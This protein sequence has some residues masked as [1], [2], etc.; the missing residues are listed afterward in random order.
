MGI[1]VD[2]VFD[3]SPAAVS[4]LRVGDIL[5]RINGTRL[6]TVF[7][8]QKSL[9]LAGIGNIITVELY[10]DGQMTSQEVTVERRPAAADSA[11]ESSATEN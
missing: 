3:P 7:D 5:T 9:Y 10:R 4:G 11:A 8:F 2:N 6:S 1:Y